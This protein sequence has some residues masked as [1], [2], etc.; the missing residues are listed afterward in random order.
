MQRKFAP[1]EFLVWSCLFAATYARNDE[2]GVGFLK[3]N[4]V[5]TDERRIYCFLH[6]R[7]VEI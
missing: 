6:T 2:R 3:V 1:H 5:L 4:D 7:Q